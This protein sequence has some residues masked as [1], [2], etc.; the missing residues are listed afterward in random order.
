ML[1]RFLASFA[2]SCI[3]VALTATAA[4]A[5]DTPRRIIAVNPFLPLAGYVQGEYEQRVRD[6]L[7]LAVSGAHMRLDDLYTSADFKLRF[8]PSGRALQG[9]GLSVGLGVGRVE[10]DD[11]FFDCL[12]LA[13]GGSDVCPAQRGETATGATASVEAQYQWLLGT[14]RST[15]VTIGA[16]A[17]R[18]Y[19]DDRNAFGYDLYQEFV[20][21]LRLTVGYAFR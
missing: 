17:K 10:N 20:P 9:F 14:K 1:R 3:A 2:A 18:F 21:T 15:A 11:V 7:S 16:G 12:T 8:Y 6:N 5:Q 13:P 4:D 19:I